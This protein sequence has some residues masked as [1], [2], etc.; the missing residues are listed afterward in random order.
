M[1]DIARHV[2]QSK[3]F[4]CAVK[5]WVSCPSRVRHRDGRRG[6][7][8]SDF[9]SNNSWETINHEGGTVL[10]QSSALQ[11]VDTKGTLPQKKKKKKSRVREY[12]LFGLIWSPNAWY[13]CSSVHT[14]VLKSLHRYTRNADSTK[15]NKPVLAFHSVFFS[16]SC[17]VFIKFLAE[18]TTI[19]HYDL[20]ITRLKIIFSTHSLSLVYICILVVSGIKNYPGPPIYYPTWRPARLKFSLT[21]AMHIMKGR[22]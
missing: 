10:L 8:N 11:N 5:M 19:L 15:Y 21:S 2:P 22:Q 4:M 1:D 18:I 12:S 16:V 9:G 13:S 14:S 3:L 20:V 6:F 7:G 17:S